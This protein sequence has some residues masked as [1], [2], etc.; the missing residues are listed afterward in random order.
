MSQQ[1]T[2]EDCLSSGTEGQT[3]QYWISPFDNWLKHDLISEEFMVDRE[4]P[5]SSAVWN[6]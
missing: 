4:G 1:K 2:V 6:G 5:A 3:D